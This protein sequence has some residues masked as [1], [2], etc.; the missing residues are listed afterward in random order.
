MTVTQDTRSGMTVMP[1]SSTIAGMESDS[2]A[3]LKAVFVQQS[4]GL[5]LVA[6]REEGSTHPINRHVA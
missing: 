6:D 4:T 2:L 1:S 5:D 3:R